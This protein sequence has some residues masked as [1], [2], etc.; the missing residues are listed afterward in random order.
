MLIPTVLEKSQFGERAYDIYSRLL[1]ER[2]VFLNDEINDDSANLVIAQLIFLAHED[3]KKDIQLYINSPGGSVTSTM[4]IYDTMN[5]IKPHVSTIC[6]GMAASGGAML[7]LAGEKGKRFALP[8]SRI[9][10]HQPHG[11][12]Q[13]QTSDIEIIT[14]EY[15]KSKKKLNELIA[16]HTGQKLDKVEKDTDRDYYMSSDEAKK[17][18]IIDDVITKAKV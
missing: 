1:K 18:G 7:L 10:I 5:F 11:G 16:K 13:G 15:L 2:I 17:Y 3:A 9:M 6:V 12:A 4:A 8:N 14:R